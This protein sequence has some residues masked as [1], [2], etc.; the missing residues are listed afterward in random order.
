MWD[1]NIPP[2]TF[3]G[4]IAAKDPRFTMVQ[5]GPVP[6]LHRLE[7]RSPNNNKALAN[8]TVRQALDYAINRL[9][10]P[11]GRRRPDDRAG[12]HP[13]PHASQP[14]G[15][16]PDYVPYP[17][18][19]TRP[20]RCWRRLVYPN[21]TLKFLYRPSSV[22]LRQERPDPSGR[23]GP[24]RGHVFRV[25]VTRSRLLRQVSYSRRTAKS[26]Y[27][28]FAMAGWTP[29]WYSDGARPTSCRCLPARPPNDEQLRLVQ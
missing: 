4:L 20:S 19:P 10:D 15:N 8:A 14:V 2:T 7:H 22:V 25:A 21:L 13:R 18:N 28:D 5:L 1:A 16:Q 23:P 12:G 11:A 27:W 6:T 17:Y 26:G 3:P 24:V 9:V 29:D